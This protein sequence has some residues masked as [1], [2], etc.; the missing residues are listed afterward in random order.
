MLR[1]AVRPL[2]DDADAQQPGPG[3]RE[4]ESVEAYRVFVAGVVARHN[5]RRSTERVEK[6]GKTLRPLPRERMQECRETRV[7]VTRSGGFTLGKV[8]YTLP[9]RMIG[10]M[11]TARV[12]DDRIE[13]YL[14]AKRYD[15]LARVR[16]GK[17]KRAR[18]V[19]YRH[20]IRSLQR[21]PMALKD[22]VHRDQLFPRDAYRRAYDEVVAKHG[23]RRACRVAVALLALAH[24]QGCERA[25]AERIDDVLDAGG[26]PDPK[27]L[28]TE[29]AEPEPGVLDIAPA[30]REG[31]LDRYDGLFGARNGDGPAVG[32]APDGAARHPEGDAR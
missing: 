23:D 28:A 11:L 3:P 19:D 32:P 13:L 21:K 24:E 10:H 25:L 5:A 17:G 12:Y 20:V 2:P 9:S 16:P 18:G 6:E 1:G 26:I 31:S 7:R 8:F 4:F 30:V 15:V 22:W 27:A 29:F 14:G